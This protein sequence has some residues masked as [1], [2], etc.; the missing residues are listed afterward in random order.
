[1]YSYYN[2]YN[3]E[4]LYVKY[5]YKLYDLHISYGN[6][7]EAAKTLLRHATML[8]FEDEA[9]PPWL[10]SRVLNRHCQTNRQLKEDLMQEAGA[11][12]TKGEDWE[13]ALI[14][15]NQL[16]PVYQ[17]I[18]I[19]YHKLSELLKKIAQLYTS[20][21]RTERAYFYYY[22][23]AFYGQGF[24]AYLNGHK[25]VF[26]SEQLEMHGE[27]MQRIMKMYDNPEKIMKTDPCPHLV[28]S[29][30]RY[31]QV[32][33]IDPIATGCSFDDNPAVNPAIKKYYRHYNIQTF[34]YSKVEDRKETKWT[35]I[36]PS[37]EFMR[38]WLVRW[39]IKTADSLPTDL[40]FT[41]VV[42]S[43]EPIYVSPLQNAV[44]R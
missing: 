26:R 35:S 40:R 11:L 17:S 36:D 15:Y 32:F 38:N 7:I 31:I 39:R 37:S 42:E 20:I 25:F 41:E 43:A 1:R 5:I 13:D 29:P 16:I 18:L 24:P 10:I 27:F 4:E 19:D 23:V 30:G 14:V 2:Q 33:N 8:N 34:E 21:D 22:L 12:F 28:S 9:L 3:H 6:K 44:D